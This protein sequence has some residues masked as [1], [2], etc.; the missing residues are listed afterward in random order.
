MKVAR[1]IVAA[2]LL[3][4]LPTQGEAHGRHEHGVAS[5]YAPKFTGRLMANG[6]RFNPHSDSAAHPRLP[7]GTRVRVVNLNN[8]RETIVTI[9]DRGPHNGRIIDLSI[10]SARTLDMERSGIARVRLEPLVEVAEAR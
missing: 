2:T 5:Y 4:I 7:F 6:E 8:G 9:R 3:A 10:A 1:A